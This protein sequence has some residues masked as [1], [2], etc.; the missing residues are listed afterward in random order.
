[1]QK[2]MKHTKLDF[3]GIDIIV[4]NDTPLFLECNIRPG[5]K[6]I[7]QSNA[8]VATEVLSSLFERA[9]AR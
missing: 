4:H 1:M 9:R 5:L 8:E 2:I 3:A 7:A 6:G